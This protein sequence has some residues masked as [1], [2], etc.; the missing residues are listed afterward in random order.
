MSTAEGAFLFPSVSATLTFFCIIS[1]LLPFRALTLAE[2]DDFKGPV[3]VTRLDARAI[4]PA[5]VE[6]L[7][8][9]SLDAF[10]AF[11]EKLE[12]FRAPT[13]VAPFGEDELK[14]QAQP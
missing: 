11:E 6:K 3:F 7:S 14:L 2:L 13:F 10:L 4:A 5:K 12:S 8:V 9:Q 1:R